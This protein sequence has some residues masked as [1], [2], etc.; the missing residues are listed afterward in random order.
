[1]GQVQ[2]DMSSDRNDFAQANVQKY[3]DA[4][5]LKV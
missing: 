3:V 1:M 4:F 5:Y 2:E